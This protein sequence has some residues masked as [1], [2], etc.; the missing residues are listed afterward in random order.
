[1]G[2]VFSESGL[3]DA[4]EYGVSAMLSLDSG[5]MVN[6]E[7]DAEVVVVAPNTGPQENVSRLRLSYRNE[8][9]LSD[10]ASPEAGVIMLT[11][12]CRSRSEQERL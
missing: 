3:P 10:G 12:S 2:R 4:L 8:A 7:R 1:M 6:G 11:Y 5:R 9:G